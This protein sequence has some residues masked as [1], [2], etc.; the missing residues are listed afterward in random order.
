MPS[1]SRGST[2]GELV[3]AI[4]PAALLI[5]MLL[6]A[7]LLAA[8]PSQS[9]PATNTGPDA[10]ADSAWTRINTGTGS[11]TTIPSLLR[12]PDGVLHVVYAQEGASVSSYEHTTVSTTGAVLGHNNVVSNWG[13]L[14]SD[15]QLIPTA[16]GGM[17]VIFGG[18]QDSDVA[19]PY[20]G[21]YLY[22]SMS[23]ATGASWAVPAEAW[24]SNG[25]GYAS[26]GTF[27]SLLPDGQT[28]AGWTLN[29][30]INYRVGPLAL[31][32]DPAT[33]A[34]PSFTE[35]GCCLYSTSSVE[36]GGAVWAAWY[37]NASDDGI[38]V[39]QIYPTQGAT[40]K[41]PL[42]ST[43][44]SSSPDQ[45][46]A[47]TRR[48]DGSVVLA[49]CVGYP[50]CTSIGLWQLGSSTVTKVPGTAGASSIALDAGPTGRL[51]LAWSDDNSDVKAARSAPTGF[52]FGGVRELD[53]PVKGGTSYHVA[54][55]AS[56]GEASVVV[57][58]G[59]NLYHRQ[60]QPGIVLS[61]SPKK[62]DG[63]K[64][65][66][67]KVKVTDAATAI[68]GAKVAGGGEKC[69]TK[70]NGTCVLKFPAHKPGKIKLKASKSGYSPAIY[71]VK[72]KP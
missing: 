14:G 55:E 61:A 43:G 34:D 48:P 44:D 15:P 24:S 54:V 66:K 52:A 21:G 16:T 3:R 30:Q 46:V 71:S 23:D 33:P 49:Y 13:A 64:A 19:N 50:T 17:R 51:W 18:L 42:S 5:T 20:S 36:T 38:F 72:V 58:D 10:R 63:D 53:R 6:P 11:N 59:T 67:V 37:S 56:L 47:M 27:A 22:T 57:N 62:W 31:P 25:T 4:R 69:T 12:M 7:V 1:S 32:V 28:L 41:A 65:T 29:S 35:P 60:V 9:A 26:Y 70:S 39:K 68:A 40:I 2:E 8:P 45:P